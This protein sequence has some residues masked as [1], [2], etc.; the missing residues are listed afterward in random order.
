MK[1]EYLNSK[2]KPRIIEINENIAKRPRE[3]E[4]TNLQGQV[5]KG[6]R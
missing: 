4:R 1:T 3:F 2:K 6:A 5:K